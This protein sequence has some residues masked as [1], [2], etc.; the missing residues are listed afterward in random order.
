MNSG[1][2]EK[3]KQLNIISRNPV[4]LTSG[5]ISDYYIDIK[6]AYGSPDVLTAIAEELWN[7]MDTRATCLATAGYGGLPLASVLSVQSGLP[8]TL[9]RIIPKQHGKITDINGYV[10]GVWDRVTIV[11]DVFTTGGSLQEIIDVLKPTHAE[12]LECAVVVKQGEGMLEVPL[13][14]VL[15]AEE[16]L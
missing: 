6:K 12:I 3:L 10:P 14:Y 1:L 15:R 13:T 16:L 11:D 8:L 9:V 7:T 5:S 2:L 4:Q